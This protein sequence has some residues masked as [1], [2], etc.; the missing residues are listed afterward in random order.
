MSTSFEIKLEQNH[1]C[2]EWCAK[3]FSYEKCG[4]GVSASLVPNSSYVNGK[5]SN[6]MKVEDA[7]VYV[8]NKRNMDKLLNLD[9]IVI[10]DDEINVKFDYPLSKS[11]VFTFYSPGGFSLR[12]IIDNI[13]TTY[14]F[15]YKSEE[16]TATKNHYYFSSKCDA[17]LNTFYGVS[18]EVVI[19]NEV[20]PICLVNFKSNEIVSKLPCLHSYHNSCINEWFLKNANCPLCRK[21]M[22]HME[23]IKCQKGII[24]SEYI[25]IVEPVDLRVKRGGLLN[26]AN[27]DGVW[28]IWGHDIS[29]LVIEGLKYNPTTKNL[30]MF[31]GS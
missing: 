30:K 29:D 18:E 27:S 9:E 28:G 24:T 2:D 21:N 10:K 22:E 20:C 8:S 3:T 17:C 11:H 14:A 4:F 13:C 23:C 25:G 16:E 12:N 5:C 7:F 6:Y 1:V 19:E 26:R 15:I 31:I